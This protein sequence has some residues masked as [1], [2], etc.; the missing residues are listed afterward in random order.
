MSGCG[1]VLLAAASAWN[2]LAAPPTKAPVGQE[3]NVA[4]VVARVDDRA[5]LLQ[6]VIGPVKA[7]LERMR[8]ALP[9]DEYLRQER[10]ILKERTERLIERVIILKEVEAKI[11]DE[12]RIAEIRKKIGQEVER[13]LYKSAREMGLKSKED[14]LRKLEEE[15]SSL[16]S[17]RKEVVDMVLAKEFLRQQMEPMIPDPTREEM[18]T[19]YRD[20]ALQF[21]QNAGV[22]WRN[23]EVRIGSNPKA[24]A[25]K[26]HLAQQRL[27]AGEDFAK[28]AKELSED[29]SAYNGGLCP[30][31][32]KGSYAEPVVDE[33]LFS[34]PVG[35]YST[36]IRGKNS[37]SFYIVKVEERTGDG[38]KPFQEVQKEVMKAMR[39]ER[40]KEVQAAKFAEFRR[41][42]FVESIY[43]KPEVASPPTGKTIR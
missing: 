7:D 13:N 18:M 40:A 4:T 21:Q 10:T 26:I 8:S 11:R 33:A 35:R 34:L 25:E 42:H 31:T 22:V 23:I 29:A 17:Q 39:S 43:D 2:Q 14:V 19:W 3:I 6:E 9:P 38:A 1:W 36:P 28:V 30:K 15:G 5:I 24:A 12:K 32:S 41:R 20:H 27:Q 16:E 37:D